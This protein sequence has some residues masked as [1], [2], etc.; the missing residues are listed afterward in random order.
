V[1]DR[2]V[3][4]LIVDDQPTFRLAARELLLARGHSVV[5][6]AEDGGGAL[7]AVARL[8]PD[9]VLLD[10]V[11]GR[12]SGFDVARALTRLSPGLPVLLVSVDGAN[13]S[14]ERVRDCGARAFLLKDQLPAADLAALCSR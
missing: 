10:V 13:V 12:E 8:T 11:L 7:D 14:G 9:A 6:E 5:A 4:V 3:R 1:H 2:P